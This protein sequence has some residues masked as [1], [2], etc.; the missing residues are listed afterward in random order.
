MELRLQ[1]LQAAL[2]SKWLNCIGIFSDACQAS[3]SANIWHT[4]KVITIIVLLMIITAGAIIILSSMLAWVGT[5]LDVFAKTSL[6]E[7]QF[8]TWR[9]TRACE[10][11]RFRHTQA[12][13]IDRH[14][15]GP[16]VK[17]I[18]G[19]QKSFDFLRAR[20]GGSVSGLRPSG[21]CSDTPTLPNVVP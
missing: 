21:M 6:A 13:A 15:R 17:V 7:I 5:E 12:S 20:T 19:L 3:T 2:C 9:G 18:H 11:D 8:C 16:E 1:F 4:T 14:K 10:R